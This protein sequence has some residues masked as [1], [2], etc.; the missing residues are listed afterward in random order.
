MT[1]K[2]WTDTLKPGDKVVLNY[3]Y[4][5]NVEKVERTTTNYVILERLDTRF[6]KDTGF[7][8]GKHS[9]WDYIPCLSPYTPEVALSVKRTKLLKDIKNTE[10]KD[11]SIEK[12][13]AIKNI[14]E[15]KTS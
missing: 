3:R 15:D 1:T 9:E 2:E 12:L 6:R 5:F 13:Q 11:F 10:Y 7:A 14:I 8:A 4:G